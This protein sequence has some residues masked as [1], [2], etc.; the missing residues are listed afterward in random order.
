MADLVTSARRAPQRANDLDGKTWTRYSIS[1]WSDLKRTKE[2]AQ[3]GHP[4]IF[5]QALAGRLIDCFTTQTQ[6]TILDPFAGIGSTLLAACERGKHAI[7]LELNGDYAAIA[8]VRLAAQSLSTP[9]S[10][11]IHV[12]DARDLL[13]YVSPESIDLV[14]TSPPY[15]DILRRRRTADAR[16]IRHYGD[17][18]GDLGTIA[19]Y[20]E[21]LAALAGI[22]Q[23]V[24]LSLRPGA[25][26]CVVVMDLRKGDRFY[27]FHSDLAAALTQI[28]YVYDD[29]IVW[30]RRQEYNF[31]RPLGYPA[32]FRINKVHEFILLLKKPTL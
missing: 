20:D 7:G 27:P 13:R 17:H 9:G 4:A 8:R 15:W 25:Y 6:R 19:D 21:F 11:E 10:A 1:I 23:D 24:F 28:G 14:V 5:P 32:V 2:E 30:D 16:T 31:L 12:A 3:W 26:A 22:F 29:L 18:E